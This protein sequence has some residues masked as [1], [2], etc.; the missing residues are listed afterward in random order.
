[1]NASL[2]YLTATFAACAS[3]GAQAVDIPSSTNFSNGTDYNTKALTGFSTESAD[4]VGSKVT[5]RFRDGSSETEVWKAAGAMGS[6]WTLK[7]NGDS[8]NSGAWELFNK[9]A[10]AIVG[11]TFDGRPGNTVFDVLGDDTNSPGSARGKPFGDVTAPDDDIGSA[12]GSYRDRLAVDGTWY[13]DLYLVLDISFK[14]PFVEGMLTYSADTDN[15]DILRG[16]ITPGIPEPGTYALMA[17][18]LAF[19][20]WSARRRASAG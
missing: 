8:F 15:A 17:A 4:M 6:S 3:M 16:G 9:G 12:M 13:K 19:V 5:V 10:K 14:S 1:M 18:G 7:L 2:R 11:L 20:G